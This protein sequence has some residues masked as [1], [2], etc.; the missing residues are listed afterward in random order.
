MLYRIVFI[1]FLH[2][3]TSP[4]LCRFQGAV[5]ISRPDDIKADLNEALVSLGLVLSFAYVGSFQ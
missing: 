4:A 1:L 2:R 5:S 3:L